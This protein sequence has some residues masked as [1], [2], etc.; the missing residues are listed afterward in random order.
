MRDF[1]REAI[2]ESMKSRVHITN[3]GMEI[4]QAMRPYL[5]PLGERP[6]AHTLFY[7]PPTLDYLLERGG[8]GA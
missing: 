8:N 4:E 1:I 7:T 2:K 6:G 3:N 5:A